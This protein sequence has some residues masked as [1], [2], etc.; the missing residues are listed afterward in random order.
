MV[1]GSCLDWWSNSI[2]CLRKGLKE[3]KRKVDIESMII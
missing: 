3:E 1:F 2:S